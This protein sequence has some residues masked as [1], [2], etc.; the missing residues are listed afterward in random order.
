MH[1]LVRMAAQ[2]Q[3]RYVCMLCTCVCVFMLCAWMCVCVCVMCVD[4]CVRVF[5]VCGCVDVGVNLHRSS[6]AR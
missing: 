3:H 1:I 4:V 6:G 2:D 5:C